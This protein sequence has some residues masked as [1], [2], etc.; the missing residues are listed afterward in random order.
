[1][2]DDCQP[3]VADCSVRLATD[4]LAHTWDPVLLMALRGGRRRRIE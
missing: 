3:F 4:L 2:N 1:M